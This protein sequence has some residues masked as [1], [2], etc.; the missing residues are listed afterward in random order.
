MTLKEY[1]APIRHD[2]LLQGKR[3]IVLGLD[4]SDVPVYTATPHPGR[5]SITLPDH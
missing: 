1:V 2:D 3:L 5:R 4:R